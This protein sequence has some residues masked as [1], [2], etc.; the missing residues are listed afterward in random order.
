MDN[1]T[2]EH[3]LL[4]VELLRDEVPSFERYPFCLPAVR[5]LDRLA[6]HPKVTFLVGE[7]GTGKSTLMEAV[8]VALGLNAEGGS[9]HFTFATRPSHSDLHRF[10]RLRRRIRR[11]SD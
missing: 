3:F 7:N 1:L 9:R 5:P 8:A 4:E 2:A 11:P 6:L 10:L